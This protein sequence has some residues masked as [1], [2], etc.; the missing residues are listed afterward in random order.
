VT[1]EVVQRVATVARLAREQHPTSPGEAATAFIGAS[2]ALFGR[3][4]PFRYTGPVSNGLEIA[5]ASPL[6]VLLLN[7]SER[8]R[9][10]ESLDGIAVAGSEEGQVSLAFLWVLVYS[11]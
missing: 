3:A 7:V 2:T 10:L 1:P 5:I 6:Y 9:K 4:D 11:V 8:L